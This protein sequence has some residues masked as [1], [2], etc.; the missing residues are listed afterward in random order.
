MPLLHMACTGAIVGSTCGT[1]VFVRQGFQRNLPFFV[2]VL[3][4]IMAIVVIVCKFFALRYTS[5]TSVTLFEPTSLLFI[6]PLSIVFLNARY[7]WKH[8]ISATITLTGLAVLV[9]SDVEESKR[10]K[11]HSTKDVIFGDFIAILAC[12]VSGLH[13]LII[14]RTTKK[15]TCKFEILGIV[16][17]LEIPESLFASY[18]FGEWGS[19]MFPSKSFVLYFVFAVLATAVV[20][21]TGILGVFHS[22]SAVCHLSLLMQ[23]FWAVLARIFILDGFKT[24]ITGFVFASVMVIG[25][26]ISFVLSGDPYAHTGLEYKRLETE[27]E[28]LPNAL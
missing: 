1:Y 15:G 7:N 19:T 2:Y 6:V 16:N 25:G 20:H 5:I 9:L 28:K 27:L 8:L 4:S 11:D 24:N 17:A 23:N 3:L 26:I 22:G 13:S 10:D 21:Y 12:C 14:E 18:L